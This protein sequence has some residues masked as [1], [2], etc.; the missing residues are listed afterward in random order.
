MNSLY[1]KAATEVL[2]IL[3][4]TDKND[5]KKISQ[6]FIKYLKNE[7]IP[8]H[9]PR[10]D[11]DEEN[12]DLVFSIETQALL[13]LIYLKFWADENEKIKFN[14]KL[15]NNER[16]HNEYI[17]SIQNKSNKFN[18]ENKENN[19][20]NEI[21]NNKLVEIKKISTFEKIILRLKNMF[22]KR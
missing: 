9:S 3:E 17:K 1:K 5:V 15:L 21:I 12:E 13:S 7:A 11:L 2:Y 20:N 8:E 14:E 18:D 19:E 16:K 4:Y 22:K 10:F 6:E